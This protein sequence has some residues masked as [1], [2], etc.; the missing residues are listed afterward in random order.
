MEQLGISAEQVACIEQVLAATANDDTAVQLEV[1]RI[2]E[3]E[4]GA[5][6]TRLRMEAVACL[7]IVAIGVI[8][9]GFKV[10]HDVAS[11][12]ALFAPLF[13]GLFGLL[14]PSPLAGRVNNGVLR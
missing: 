3:H 14:A 7:A 8:A 12:T 11:A 5:R 10:C 9:V 2:V 13:T 6:T 1:L 4:P